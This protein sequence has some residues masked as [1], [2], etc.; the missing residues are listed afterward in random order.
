MTYL[1]PLVAGLLVAALMLGRRRPRVRVRMAH[2]ASGRA[3]GDEHRV[4]LCPVWASRPWQFHS[5]KGEAMTTHKRVA[6]VEMKVWF[7][8]LVHDECAW[9]WRLYVGGRALEQSSAES[10]ELAH[11]AAAR[12]AE[13]IG[14]LWVK[15]EGEGT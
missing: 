5:A 3:A 1:L 13:S 2:A 7:A 10:E 8:P 6:T 11:A 15:P 14:P 9:H 12:C 4:V